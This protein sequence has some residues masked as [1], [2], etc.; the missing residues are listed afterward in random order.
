MAAHQ[1]RIYDV[2]FSPVGGLIATA[3]FNGGG[4]SNAGF[5]SGLRLWDAD[6][7]Q[8]VGQLAF[9]DRQ[10]ESVAFSADGRWLA[11]G[12]ALGEVALW[13]GPA[14]WRANACSI[15]GH[16]LTGDE[17]ARFLQPDDAQTTVCRS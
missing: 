1:N 17:R 7:G 12:G 9:H 11:S 10:V 2:A 16:D 13:P 15:A 14:S 3:G 4:T 5:D 8:Q 6:T